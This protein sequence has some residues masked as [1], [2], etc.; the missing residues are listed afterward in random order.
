VLVL[1]LSHIMRDAGMGGA[2]SVFAVVR[3]RLSCAPAAPDRA[4]KSVG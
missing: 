4:K 2:A 1:L 3:H